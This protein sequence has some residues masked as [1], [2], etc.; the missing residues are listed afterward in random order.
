VEVPLFAAVPS[1]GDT[2]TV[3]YDQSVIIVI[4]L[5]FCFLLLFFLMINLRSHIIT[6]Q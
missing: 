2:S 5:L 1:E 3:N 6:T 4:L